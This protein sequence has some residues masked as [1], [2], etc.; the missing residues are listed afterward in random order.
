[1]RASAG[2]VDLLRG[3][4]NDPE[5]KVSKIHDKETGPEGRAY[6]LLGDLGTKP[7]VLYLKKVDKDA[8]EPAHA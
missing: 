3:D 8:K 2:G 4:L 7:N 5:S 6:R 1:M